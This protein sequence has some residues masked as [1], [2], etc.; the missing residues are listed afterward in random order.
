MGTSDLVNLSS[1]L[2]DAKCFALVRQH[3][4]AEG[5]SRTGRG[6]A[7]C[8]SPCPRE[9]ARPQL[10]NTKGSR[11]TA[12]QIIRSQNIYTVRNLKQFVYI[13]LRKVP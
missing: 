8:A 13:P 5:M 3:R 9:E 12:R 6:G 2:D 1:L 7:T 10:A 11:T 4:W